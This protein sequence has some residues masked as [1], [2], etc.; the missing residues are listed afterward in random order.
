MQSDG[1]ALILC[2]CGKEKKWNKNQTL[3]VAAARAGSSRCRP[4]PPPPPQ[5]L[6][7][8]T[9]L[10]TLFFF[11]LSPQFQKKKYNKGFGVY[12]CQNCRHFVGIVQDQLGCLHSIRSTIWLY[13]TH[14]SLLYQPY[15]SFT[16]WGMLLFTS[17]IDGGLF[18]SKSIVGSGLLLLRVDRRRWVS[19]FFIFFLLYFYVGLG[20]VNEFIDTKGLL[21]A[22]F[23][24]KM[25]A[26]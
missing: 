4:Y 7:S 1:L 23:R 3:A 25:M 17:T 9:S 2:S 10:L 15:Q 16:W 6:P 13:Q 8:L 11:L 12:Y 24:E 22:L 20:I 26:R 14:R 19:H 18:F 5:S 21:S